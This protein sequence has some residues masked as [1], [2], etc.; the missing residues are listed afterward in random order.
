MFVLRIVSMVFYVS[1]SGCG[2]STHF[3]SINP[4]PKLQIQNPQTE[5]SKETI[6]RT[7]SNRNT[8]TKF[9]ERK[10]HNI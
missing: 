6:T 10:S 5:N 4:T 9:K 1:G 3:K 2:I 7:N 8:G